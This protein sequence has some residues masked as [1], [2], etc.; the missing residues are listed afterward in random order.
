[1]KSQNIIIFRVGEYADADIHL[2]VPIGTK[3]F[4]CTYERNSAVAIRC[5]VPFDQ[6]MDVVLR[7]FQLIDDQGHLITHNEQGLLVAVWE[8]V[9]TVQC[10]FVTRHLF[11][12]VKK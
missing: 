7:I 9:C 4:N 1:M 3:V 6:K 2:K 11:E 12:N 8:H 5:L 10:G